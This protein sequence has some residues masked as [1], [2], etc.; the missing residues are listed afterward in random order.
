M[1]S[2][3]EFE[4]VDEEELADDEFPRFVVNTAIVVFTS[5]SLPH[6]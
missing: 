5:K 4:V 3:R 6:P 1:S 2:L